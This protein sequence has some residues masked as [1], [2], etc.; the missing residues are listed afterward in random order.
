MPKF[1]LITSPIPHAGKT[2]IGSAV[3]LALAKLGQRVVALK[4]VETGVR[5]DTMDRE[6]GALLAQATGQAAPRLAILRFRHRGTPAEAAQAD[7][8]TIQFQELVD[9]I[10]L[11][12]READ[13]VLI[14][15]SGEVG[16]PI[17]GEHTMLDLARAL[18]ARALLVL[19][20][21]SSGTRALLDRF[22]TK[23]VP[24]A[25]VVVNQ[26]DAHHP[27]RGKLDLPDHVPI[28]TVGPG[29]QGTEPFRTVAKWLA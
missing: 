29:D 17:D 6:D 1:C 13:L 21:W 11:L 25:G 28:L 2:F 27:D 20:D 9:T 4:A 5:E 19:P 3:A 26:R 12:G 16:A 23:R 14:E 22:A 24:I 18:G 7:G 15:D 10:R 8:T